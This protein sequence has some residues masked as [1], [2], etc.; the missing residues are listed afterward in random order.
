VVVENE[1][2]PN[3]VVAYPEPKVV[4]AE[5]NLEK[6]AAVK[7]PLF[8][9]VADVQSNAPDTPPTNEPSVPEYVIGAVTVGVDVETV[10]SNPE[11]PTY[12]LPCVRD[13]K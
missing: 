6:S 5:L 1:S 8:E 10:V 13:G 7:H 9:A 3:V 12:A 4:V 2:D 11:V